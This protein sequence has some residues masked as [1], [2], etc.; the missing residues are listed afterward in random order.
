M[1]VS[2]SIIIFFP[3][4]SL[5]HELDASFLLEPGKEIKIEFDY[6]SISSNYLK[7]K[8]HAFEDYLSNSTLDVKVKKTIE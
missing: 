6:G 5:C 4:I 7:N 1:L 3:N 8:P 2:V